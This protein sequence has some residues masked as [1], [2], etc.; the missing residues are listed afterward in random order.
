[1]NNII[2]EEISDLFREGKFE[3]IF[4]I[5]AKNLLKNSEEAITAQIIRNRWITLI[6][7][8]EYL[9]SSE[10]HSSRNTIYT[11]LS[12][13]VNSLAEKSQN[14]VYEDLK[15][16]DWDQS[17]ELIELNLQNDKLEYALQLMKVLIEK[18]DN[19]GKD[20]E[21][22]ISL[23]L[24]RFHQL[25]REQWRGVIPHDSFR[26]ERAQISLSIFGIFSKLKNPEEIQETNSLEK[27]KVRIEKELKKEI[28][29]KSAAKFVDQSI[30]QLKLRESNLNRQAKMWNLGGLISLII[31]VGVSF[32]L[33]IDDS[34]K[35]DDTPSIIY[36]LLKGLV[37]IGL[38]VATARYTFILGKTYMNESLKNADRIHAISFGKFF[39]QVFDNDISKED[40][41]EVF[42]DWNTSSESQFVKLQ[43]SEFDPK[44]VEEFSKFIQSVKKA[45]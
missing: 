42:K 3:E 36:T 19:I 5:L 43:S 26:L 25:K 21:N 7:Q 41:K 24:S 32:Y 15:D 8:K 9:T 22:G 2:L 33:I 38:L 16:K 12:E 4:S 44:Y 29:Q 6:K 23:I 39:L 34:I 31:G 35:I 37:I 20:L 14:L 10:Y 18:G 13:F 40:L 1:M 27:E 11:N 28:L 17:L 30:N 45:N